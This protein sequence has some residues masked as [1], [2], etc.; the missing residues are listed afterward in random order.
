MVQGNG[1]GNGRAGGG[2]AS[3]DAAALKRGI[4]ELAAERDAVIIS[5]YYCVPDVHDVADFVGDSL[6]L[7]QEAQRSPRSVVVFCG[8]HFMAETASILCPDKTVLL[9][10]IEAGCPMA[11]MITP[12]AL[13]KRKAELPGVPVLTYVNSS[14]A[15]KAHSDICCTSANVT[16]VMRSLPGG[17][18]L[19]TPDRNLALRTQTLVPDKEILL[20]PGF[21]PTHHRVNAEEVRKLKREHPDA[22]V[23]AHPECQPKILA[24]AH[25][26]GSTSG[27]IKACLESGRKEFVILTEEG[28][29]YPLKRQRPDAVFLTPETPM[30]CPNM[31]KVTLLDVL[32]ALETMTPV[33]KVPEEIR[34]PAL[35]AVE[36]MMAVPRD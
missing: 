19:M 8:V 7:S 33:I 22:L 32:K 36:R 28:V 21:C 15:V 29:I 2:D 27:I 13:V 10:N 31:K 16:A 17:R 24:E 4:R 23:L 3:R 35:R 1:G 30:V 9:A 20:W 18:I 11:D 34:V 26:V 6:G 25:V 12:E 14:A 5:H